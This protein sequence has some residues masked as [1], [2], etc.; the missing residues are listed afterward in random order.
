MTGR[1]RALYWALMG[2]IAV[3]NL[4]LR[5]GFP[6]RGITTAAFDDA[7][8]IRQ[9]RFLGG[10]HWLG[11]FD[12]V[13][14]A[15]G[16]FYPLFIAASF[17]AAIP[18]NVAQQALYLAS[19]TLAA[20]LVFRLS[21]DLLLA[22]VLF[23]VLAFNPVVLNWEM[24]RVIRE[25]IYLSQSLAV[26]VLSI[27]CAFPP[28]GR[29]LWRRIGYGVSLG[30]VLGT[31]WLTREEGPWI[32]PAMA[33]VGGASCLRALRHRLRQWG[34]VVGVPLLAAACI[35]GACVGGVATVNYVRYGVFITN[36]FTDGSFPKAYGALSRIGQDH[37]RQYVVFPKDA[38]ER[39]YS[40]SPA[41][42]ELAP[43]LDGP[44]GEEWRRIG[45]AQTDTDPCPEILSGWF[46]WA[47]REATATAGHYTSAVEAGRFY[48]R[49]AD[50]I[51]AACD[52][53]KIPCGPP[54]RTLVPIFHREYLAQTMR[55]MV[56]LGRIVLSMGNQEIGS[57]PSIGT[58]SDVTMFADMVG[59]L[60]R[61]TPR[62]ECCK[63]G[64][65][66]RSAYR[67]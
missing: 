53:G 38:R 16:M 45:C 3:F 6:I 30:L 9:A 26:I 46:M 25:G 37:W 41:A 12:N 51:D 54:R 2:A 31:F 34:H 42:R 21:G 32:L 62:F 15:K 33:V 29:K 44:R 14:L 8:F 66:L 19:A 27:E 64:R 56:E 10:G 23:I 24:D 65:P 67:T 7:L 1:A 22:S 61:P 5:T 48:N 63:A 28:A 20:R 50:E 17:F 4:W 59:S 11:P 60:I 40:V 58:Q 13:T 36:D 18:L 49:L 39:A 47:L 35:Y 43:V 52:T 57:Q 55:A